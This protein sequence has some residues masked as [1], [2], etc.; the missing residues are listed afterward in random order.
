MNDNVRIQRAFGEELHGAF[1]VWARCMRP[2]IKAGTS[3]TYEICQ[4]LAQIAGVVEV[5]AAAG[6]TEADRKMGEEMERAWSFTKHDVKWKLALA[7]YYVGGLGIPIVARRAKASL[8][9][10][11]DEIVACGRAVNRTRLNI[12]NHGQVEDNRAYNL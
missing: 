7:S 5:V 4:R 10:T 3:P 8:S 1:E 11:V 6:M 9:V 2:T 12:R